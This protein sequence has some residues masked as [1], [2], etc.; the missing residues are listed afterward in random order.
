[1]K[2]R[3]G[4]LKTID[5]IRKQFYKDLVEGYFGQEIVPE[6]ASQMVDAVM[7]EILK[8]EKVEE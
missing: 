6:V 7:K 1:M 2:G 3:R 8:T 5:G 4:A